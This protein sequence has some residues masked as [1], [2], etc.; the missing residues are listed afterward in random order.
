LGWGRVID[1]LVI[2]DVDGGHYTMLQE[3]FAEKVAE[4]MATV[5]DQKSI[6]VERQ[7][8]LKVSA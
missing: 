7:P 8:A 6:P 4:R 1:H 5:L 2:E 3:P